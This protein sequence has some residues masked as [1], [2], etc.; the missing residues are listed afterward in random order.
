MLMARSWDESPFLRLLDGLFLEMCC[1]VV[2]GAS[3]AAH[4]GVPKK[5]VGEGMG[6]EGASVSQFG[7][8]VPRPSLA[9]CLHS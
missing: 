5:R 6:A 7:F 4:A 8:D 9:Y 2:E 1:V 3:S